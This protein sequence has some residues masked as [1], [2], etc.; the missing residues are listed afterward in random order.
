MSKKKPHHTHNLQ[1]QTLS[2]AQTDEYR[3]SENTDKYAIDVPKYS[4]RIIAKRNDYIKLQEEVTRLLNEGWS[5][6]GGV[7][8]ALQADPYGVVT[9]YTQAVYRLS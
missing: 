6:A 2:A 9:M 5:L 3:P 8:T 1:K 4:Y 7:S